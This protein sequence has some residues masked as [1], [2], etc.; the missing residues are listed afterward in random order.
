MTF[1]IVSLDEPTGAIGVATATGLMAVGAQVPHCRF[2]LGA[3]V[4]QGHTTNPLYASE[5]MALLERGHEAHDVVRALIEPDRDRERRQ[6]MVVDRSGKAAAWTGRKNN[7]V[8]RHLCERNWAVAGNLLANDGVLDAM[9]EAY[10]SS[11]DMPHAARLIGALK[12][13]QRAGG[14]RRGTCSAALMVDTGQG[15]PL[16]LRVDYAEDPIGGLEDLYLRSLDPDYR[17]F[18][19][20]LPTHIAPSGA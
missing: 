1:S 10:L 6:L 20:R 12:S 15:A 5:G 8:K 17:A 11:R 4:T 19:A 7:E 18:L 13:G 14:D 2:A 16:D 3:I 9:R